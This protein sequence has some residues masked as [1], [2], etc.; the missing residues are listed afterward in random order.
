[1]TY[2]LCYLSATEAL[3]QFRSRDLSPVELM[4]A[5]IARAEEQ[6][7]VINAFSD[8][9]FDAALDEARTSEARYARGEPLGVLDG[10]AVA[11]KDEVDVAGQR[12]TEGSL[13]YQNRVADNDAVLTARLRA[14]VWRHP[15]PLEPGSHSGWLIRRIGRLAGGRHINARNRL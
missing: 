14:A 10:L 5:L 9:F 2:E 1:M 7:P 3:R 11:I 4:E 8:T 13:I 15:Q 12:N 6:E